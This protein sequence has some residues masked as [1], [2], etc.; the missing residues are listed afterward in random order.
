MYLFLFLKDVVKS[1]LP[2]NHSTGSS[3]NR[4]KGG[5]KWAGLTWPR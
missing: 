5:V 3:H 4:E 1:N 2:E